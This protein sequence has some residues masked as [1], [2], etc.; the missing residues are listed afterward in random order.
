M[1]RL[2]D[3]D[4]QMKVLDTERQRLLADEAQPW[5]RRTT[6]YLHSSKES[7]YDVAHEVGLEENAANKFMY[8]GYE[9]SLE[10]DVNQ[11]GSWRILALDGQALR[12]PLEGGIG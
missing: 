2:A 9:V 11:D 6:V 8:F 4:A 5:P 12:K 1:S 7:M 10:V 3:I